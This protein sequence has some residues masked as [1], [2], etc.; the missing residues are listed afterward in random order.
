MQIYLKPQQPLNLGPLNVRT[1]TEAAQ[2]SCLG[3]TMDSTATVTTVCI[4]E[5]QMQN[6]TGVIQL[7]APNA[8]LRGRIC[9]VVGDGFCLL[10]LLVT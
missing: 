2:Q 7:A 6:P 1:L 5:T 4:S 3:S 9:T 10:K 8:S